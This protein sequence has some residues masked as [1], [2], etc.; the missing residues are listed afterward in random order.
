MVRVTVP[1]E[2]L[3]RSTIASAAREEDIDRAQ[4]E[5]DI[6]D[7][8]LLAVV[9]PKEPPPLPSVEAAAAKALRTP[10]AGPSFPE[11]LGPNKRVAVIVDNQF[12]PTPTSR[13]LKPLLDI[14]EEKRVRHACLA[15]GGMMVSHAVPLSER[16]LEAKLGRENLER[17]Q[18]LGFE[19]FQNEPKNPE[20][21][22]FVGLTRLGTPVWVNRRVAEC[23]VKVALPLTQATEYG[24]GGGGKLALAM[25]SEE[26]I[27]VNHR[28]TP[29][30]SPEA[31]YGALAC[32]WRRDIDEIAE[33]VG[34]KY[35]LNTIL[36]V[37]HFGVAGLTFGR[38]PD[39]FR[40]S[41]ERYNS[42]FAYD[43]PGLAER[44]ADI[45]I[46]GTPAISDHLF[47]HTAKGVFSADLVCKD[48]GTIIFC[49]P[50]RGIETSQGFFPG[51]SWW[52]DF[53]QPYMPPSRENYERILKDVCRGKIPLWSGCVWIP[54]YEVLTRKKLTVVTEK[55]NLPDAQKTFDA[56]SSLQEAFDEAL[57]RHGKDAKVLV[58]P[59]PKYQ[60]PKWAVIM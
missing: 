60:L 7:S 55:E 43:V 19:V 53:F 39:S 42:I 20:A 9:N 54:L 47:F 17:V 36:C 12:R 13:Y 3:P 35:A 45:V 2:S 31:K 38:L 14:L 28:F 48:G 56:T 29:P 11:L 10:V 41:V 51:F 23:D 5:V 46:C 1:Y 40:V 22:I 57:R 16:D 30:V 25:C 24:Y 21:N 18:K 26:T 33:I 59:Y 52:S 37:S 27:E 49:S 6:P 58:V 15:V 44:K 8:N 32:P 50:A 34:L 4:L